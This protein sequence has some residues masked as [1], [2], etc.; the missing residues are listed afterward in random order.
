M[1]TEPNATNNDACLSL[2]RLYLSSK[3]LLKLWHGSYS[4]TTSSMQLTNLSLLCDNYWQ[5]HRTEKKRA[6]DG[7]QFTRSN[8][9]RPLILVR[10]AEMGIETRNNDF[11]NHIA[12][13]HLQT[14]HT[15]NWNRLTLKSWFTNLEK[16]PVKR[17]LQLPAPYKRLIDNINRTDEQ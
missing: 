12:E 6:T 11:N 13:H 7:K 14:T 2:L 1:D 8:A 16:T 10:P 3:A 17:C 4:P 15:I 9:A 5:T